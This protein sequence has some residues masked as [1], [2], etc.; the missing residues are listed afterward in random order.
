MTNNELLQ[1]QKMLGMPQG[2]TMAQ[3]VPMQGY[4]QS[5]NASTALS[6]TGNVSEYK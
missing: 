6:A 1:M 2:G 3:A 4:H 5:G